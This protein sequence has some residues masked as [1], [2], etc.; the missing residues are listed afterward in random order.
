MLVLNGLHMSGN[1]YAFFLTCSNIHQ[2]WV[3]FNQ[4][5]DSHKRPGEAQTP[6][7]KATL[8]GLESAQQVTN[9]IHCRPRSDKARGFQSGLA[10]VWLRNDALSTFRLYI[11]IAHAF[12]SLRI[13]KGQADRLTHLYIFTQVNL[14]LFKGSIC[15]TARWTLPESLHCRLLN[16]AFTTSD[17]HHF[18]EETN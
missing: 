16:K 7:T 5:R 14:F 17:L 12:G 15:I 3:L 11:E 18:A 1:F 8:M 4:L 9:R 2:H 10:P 13:F 6:L